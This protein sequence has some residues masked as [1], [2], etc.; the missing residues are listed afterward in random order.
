MENIWIIA[1]VNFFTQIAFI[2]TRTL[3][4]K[5]VAGNYLFKALVSGGLVHITWLISISLS[6]YS[7]VALI[8]DW[9]WSYLPVPLASLTGGLLGTY[10][11][12]IEKKKVRN[13]K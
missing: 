8:K 10:F 1:I 9:D 7:V 4:V 12:M 6:T 3:N 5:A 13:W 11:G 2:W